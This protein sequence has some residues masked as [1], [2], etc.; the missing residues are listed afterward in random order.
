MNIREYHVVTDNVIVMYPFKPR[1]PFNDAPQ[2]VPCTCIALPKELI[3][4]DCGVYPDLAEI[5]RRDMEKKFKRECSHLLLTHTHWDHIL[6]MEVFKDVTAVASETGINDLNNFLKVLNNKPQED[7]PGILNTTEVE[8]I[9][10]LAKSNIFL[11]NMSVK[12]QITIGEKDHEVIFRVIG[13]HSKD[14]A[15]I[16]YPKE[17]VLCGGDNLIECYYQLSGSPDETLK[18]IRHWDSLDINFAIPGHGKVVNKDFITN[19]RLYYEDLIT[20]LE[21]LIN[22]GITRKKILTHPQ[23]PQYFGKKQS[24]WKEGCFPNSNWMEMTIRRWYH[25]LKSKNK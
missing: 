20:V 5:F 15:Y 11:P 9:E 22:Q 23:L 17:K 2:T 19:L 6:A 25:Y 14:S 8:V 12:E 1:Y 10:I 13:G 7:W 4:V 24:N 21:E 16:F 3:F 18:I